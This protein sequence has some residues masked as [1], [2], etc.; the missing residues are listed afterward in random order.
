MFR[1][2]R[3]QSSISLMLPPSP[4]ENW[5][6]KMKSPRM[7]LNGT[8]EKIYCYI[9]YSFP[10]V[11]LLSSS[12]SSSQHDVLASWYVLS[13]S[14]HCIH[15]LRRPLM[16]VPSITGE[17]GHSD[18]PLP[19]SITEHQSDSEYLH[20]AAAPDSTSYLYSI[21]PIISYWQVPCRFGNP[22]SI[23]WRRTF[24]IYGPILSNATYDPL[25]TG[26]QQDPFFI[27]FSTIKLWKIA[28]WM[29]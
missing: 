4:T 18:S 22:P 24:I 9:L 13:S 23:L 12:M 19:T 5:K 20:K 7:M 27:S 29:N 6:N 1:G 26:I 3:L 14:L 16:N 11:Q 17:S 8:T 25:S 2:S 28:L 10:L 21:Y 15:F